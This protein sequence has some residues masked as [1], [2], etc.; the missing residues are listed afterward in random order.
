MTA[1]SC[2]GDK[3][4]L[5]P[6]ASVAETSSGDAT[7]EPDSSNLDFVDFF[8]S[9]NDATI[10]AAVEAEIS[11]CMTDR[12]FNYEPIAK[13][14]VAEMNGAVP[15]GV[16]G[17]DVGFG[18]VD[19]LLQ[20]PRDD[21][22]DALTA[23][24]RLL[25][26]FSPE[27]RAAFEAALVGDITGSSQ[28][29]TTGPG[30]SDANAETP[31]GCQGIAQAKV[32]RTVPSLDPTF[33]AILDEYYERLRTD[34]EVVSAEERWAEC[35]EKGT[36]VLEATDS[37][38]DLARN[39]IQ[40]AVT[41]EIAARLG[42]SIRWV[43]QLEADQISMSDYPEPVSM[44]VDQS[45]VGLLLF[46]P[47]DMATAEAI[48]QAKARDR[49]IF[50]TSESCWEQSGGRFEVERL[51]SEAMAKVEPLMAENPQLRPSDDS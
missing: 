49:Q 14:V 6:R 50:T 46:G 21:R 5:G 22:P 34:A 40:Y 31:D 27:E 44:S 8:W 10:Q 7:A 47:V 32:Y 2:G 39:N 3:E 20:Q 29:A 19:N 36:G 51:Q 30:A 41:A 25:A 4:A 9:D 16:S 26:S 1:Y 18:V 43:T 12:G 11:R 42:K 15:S 38:L 45:G 17:P 33:R 23:R 48:E 35:V 37:P 28:T 24:E 13:A